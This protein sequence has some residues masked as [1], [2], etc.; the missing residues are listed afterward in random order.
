MSLIQDVNVSP[1]FG[2]I[3]K[4]VWFNVENNYGVF[5]VNLFITPNQSKDVIITIFNNE[6]KDI[7]FKKTY[8]KSANK[9]VITD[10]AKITHIPGLNSIVYGIKNN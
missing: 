1:N 7:K 6:T 3:N 5:D 4:V 9:T 2:I 10:T 8:N